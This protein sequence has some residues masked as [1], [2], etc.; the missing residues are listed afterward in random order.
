MYDSDVMIDQTKKIWEGKQSSLFLNVSVTKKITIDI[1]I[2][3]A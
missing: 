3:E 2:K 1:Q